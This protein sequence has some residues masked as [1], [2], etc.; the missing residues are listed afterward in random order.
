MATVMIVFAAYGLW[1]LHRTLRDTVRVPAEL[2]VGAYLSSVV[3]AAETIPTEASLREMVTRLAL[4]SRLDEVVV[5]ALFGFEVVVF[6]V[7]SVDSD[8]FLFFLS[9]VVADPRDGSVV[10]LDL[11]LGAGA[12][13]NV[14]DEREPLGGRASQR[15]RWVVT[16]RCPIAIGGANRDVFHPR[17]LP[18]RVTGSSRRARQFAVKLRTARRMSSARWG[19]Q[20]SRSGSQVSREL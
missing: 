6:L 12:S 11:D 10:V 16:E 3:A 15:P 2:S 5:V 19:W 9:V 8:G 4:G 7:A 18:S 14:V 17:S 20:T 1:Q 13:A